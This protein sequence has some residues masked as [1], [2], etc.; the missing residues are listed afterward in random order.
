[1][2]ERIE[3]S[4]LDLNDKRPR[5]VLDGQTARKDFDQQR[6]SLIDQ[7]FICIENDTLQ[8]KILAQ[9][10][11]RKEVENTRRK[12]IIAVLSRYNLIEWKRNVSTSSFGKM[13]TN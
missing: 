11:S 6:K 5:P 8:A 13:V 3:I 1:M 10:G 4:L 9:T 7:G 12:A 2:S